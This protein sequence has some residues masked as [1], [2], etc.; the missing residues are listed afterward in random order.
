[1][2]E[3]NMAQRAEISSGNV[4]ADLGLPNPKALL[5]LADAKIEWNKTAAEPIPDWA[6]ELLAKMK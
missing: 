4:F 6:K 1:M 2:T 3:L 5:A